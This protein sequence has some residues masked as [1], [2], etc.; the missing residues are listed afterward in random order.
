MVTDPVC[1]MEVIEEDAELG[2][3]VSTYKDKQY[4]FCARTCKEKFDADP[5]KYVKKSA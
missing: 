4:Y 2:A 3:N 1:E 5:E